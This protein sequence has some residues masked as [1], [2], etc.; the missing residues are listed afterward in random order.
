[1]SPTVKT[2]LK[3]ALFGFLAY[4][5]F[6]VSNLPADFVYAQWKNHFGS[7]VPVKLVQLEGSVWSGSA[8]KAIV[9]GQSFDSLTWSM[10]FLTLLLGIIELDWE[11]K[12]KDGYAK[13]V[14]GMSLLGGTYFHDV[15]AWLPL[16][17]LQKLLKVEALRPGG[18]IDVKLA[19][20]KIE[21]QSIVTAQGD[22]AWHG[23]EMTLLGKVELG[24]LQVALEPAEEG[25]KGVLSDQGG[26]L[27]AEGIF[28]LKPDRSYEFTGAFGA[29]SQ[30]AELLQALSSLGPPGRD[31]KFKVSRSGNLDQLGF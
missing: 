8:G 9:N 6:L 3:Y 24:D 1:M 23:A 19:N 18:A 2:N 30:S 10:N 13:G 31:G 26:A 7:E 11:F 27:Q 29:R 20:L 12:V 22:L 4:I 17:Q 21:D 25:I 15:E 28:T 5:V 14:T 16:S